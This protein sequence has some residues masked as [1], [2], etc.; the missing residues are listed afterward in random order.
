MKLNK[1]QKT[2]NLEDYFRF[3]KKLPA[4]GQMIRLKCIHTPGVEEYCRF[5]EFRPNNIN[6]IFFKSF[7]TGYEAAASTMVQGDYVWHYYE[8]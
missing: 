8:D 6:Q 1:N 3:E 2:L 4:P 5:I 7:R